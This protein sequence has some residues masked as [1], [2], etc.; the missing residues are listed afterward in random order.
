M[1]GQDRMEEK[2]LL[3]FLRAPDRPQ[4]RHGQLAMGERGKRGVLNK[5]A[6]PGLRNSFLT[7]RRCAAWTASGVTWG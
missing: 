5:Q 7:R 3:S 2:S 4:A 6:C 1:D